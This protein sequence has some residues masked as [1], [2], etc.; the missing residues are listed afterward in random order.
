MK[1]VAGLIVGSLLLTA[2][3]GVG[4]G[5]TPAQT[6]ASSVQG[7]QAGV[8][9]H[10]VIGARPAPH[11]NQP[12]QAL[13][14]TKVSDGSLPFN[15]AKA[16][17]MPNGQTQLRGSVATS[18]GIP[19]D[20]AVVYWYG[21]TT[22]TTGHLTVQRGQFT[23]TLPTNHSEI[24]VTL[25]ATAPGYGTIVEESLLL[26]NRQTTGLNITVPAAGHTDTVCLKPAVAGPC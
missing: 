25:K 24:T 22:S 9:E 23:L 4:R 8:S 11:P 6:G 14:V 2:G 13:V 18:A 3:C 17:P 10:T 21:P 7:T 1:R 19:V 16:Y 5:A 15:Y 20:D 12:S 26:P